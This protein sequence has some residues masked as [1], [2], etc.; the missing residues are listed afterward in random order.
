ML[1]NK[2]VLFLLLF[3]TITIY[4]Q[5]TISEKAFYKWFDTTI[6]QENSGLIDGL[7]YRELYRTQ[8]GNHKFYT[9]SAFQKGHITYNGQRYF[10]VDL[11]YDIHADEIIIKIP[12]QTITHTIQ[13]IKEHVERFSIK[14]SEFIALKNGFYE[15]IFKSKNLSFYKKHIKTSN[16]YYSGRS[17][18]Y[19]FKGKTEYVLYFNNE[20][21]SI[22]KSKKS[23]IKLMPEFKKEINSFY[24]TKNELLNINYDLFMQ[25]LVAELNNVISKKQV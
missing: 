14:N 17:I 2:A 10:D 7:A 6:G 21:H 11:K 9:T 4:S 23:L 18:F 8:N 5:T 3:S 15:I 22:S 16:K 24:K 12:T 1:K 20:Y 13:L 25:Q 19:R